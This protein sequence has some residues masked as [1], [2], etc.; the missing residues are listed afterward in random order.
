[1]SRNEWEESKQACGVG[2]H[3]EEWSRRKALDGERR[4]NKVQMSVGPN[5]LASLDKHVILQLR[6]FIVN[7]L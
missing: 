7:I 6:E 3:S 5:H 4:G 2:T 1:M